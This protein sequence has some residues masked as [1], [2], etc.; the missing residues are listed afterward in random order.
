MNIH[1]SFYINYL[2]N[3]TFL[4]LYYIFVT[5][6]ILSIVLSTN[7]PLSSRVGTR[8]VNFIPANIY[9]EKYK[10]PIGASKLMNPSV[11]PISSSS[12]AACKSDQVRITLGDDDGSI[13]VSYVSY[14]LTTK[15]EVKY[16]TDENDLISSSSSSSMT[17][18][19][20]SIYTATGS[21]VSYSQLLYIVENL[22]D[23]TMG[24]PS[25]TAQYV[26]NLENSSKWAYDKV[27][28][29][30]WAN[31]LLISGSTPNYG[32]GSYN[33]PY[34]YYDSPYIHTVTIKGLS[35]GTP[36][37]YQPAGSC[38]IYRFVIPP[39]GTGT[40]RSYPFM[41]GLTCDIGQTAVSNASVNALI[42]MEPDVVLIGGDLSYAD[43]WTPL[44]DTFG[45]MIEPLASH[46]PLLTTGTNN[47]I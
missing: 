21:S 25:Q 15:S 8:N 16:S 42:S 6:L 29:E 14:N 2:R 34:M 5:H 39:R 31:Y 10:R 24:S 18:T 13:V 23:P 46:I 37:Y 30:H 44:W 36:Y 38:K 22:I 7:I 28:G 43:G 12:G 20:S 40:S 41:V 1:L 9:G 4:I 33:N 11:S 47:S 35:A 26:I 27:T 45:R 32:S 17:T 19:T 3:M